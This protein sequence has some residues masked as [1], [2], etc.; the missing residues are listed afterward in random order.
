MSLV[1]ERPNRLIAAAVLLT[2]AGLVADLSVEL[3]VAAGVW[4]TAPVLLSLWMPQRRYAVV[5][6]V[7]GTAL[8]TI[9]LFYSP[10]GGELWKVLFNRALVLIVIWVAALLVLRF[11][12]IEQ[13]LRRSEERLYGYSSDRSTLSIPVYLKEARLTVR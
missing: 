8:T 11:R 10:P 9:G 5:F 7:T 12:L 1:K 3:G 6:A 13:G 2:V 4:Y